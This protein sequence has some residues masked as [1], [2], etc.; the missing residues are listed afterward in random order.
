MPLVIYS[1]TPGM[2]L[3]KFRTLSPILNLWYKCLVLEYH[4]PKDD[5]SAI[6]GQ[7]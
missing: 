6:L 7:S 1:R 4:L 5:K 3:L 2:L